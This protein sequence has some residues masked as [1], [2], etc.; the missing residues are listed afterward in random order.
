MEKLGMRYER[1][2]EVFGLQAV[3]YLLTREAFA[4]PAPTG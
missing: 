3:C 2:V 4:G 1:D